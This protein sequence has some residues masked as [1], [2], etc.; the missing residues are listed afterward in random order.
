MPKDADP[1]GDAMHEDRDVTA[2]AG[3]IERAVMALAALERDMEEDA[4]RDEDTEEDEETDD[5]RFQQDSGDSWTRGVLES[6]LEDHAM[7]SDYG[8]GNWS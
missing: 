2:S 1:E 3:S 5:E 7:R 4:D 8:D 6:W